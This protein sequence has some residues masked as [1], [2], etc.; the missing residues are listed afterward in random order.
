MEKKSI[1]SFIAALRKANG[2]TQ[3][4]LAEK[5]NVSDKTVSRWE[6][7]EGTPDLSL[8]PVI[9]EL[10]GVTS[11]ELLLGQRR[12]SPPPTAQNSGEKQR[13]RLLSA[14][15]ARYRNATCL[16]AGLAL[17]GL[18]AALVGNF[19]F[20]RAYLGFF[21]GAALLLAAGIIQVAAVN[22][23]FLAIDSEDI[24]PEQTA[25]YRRQVIRAAERLSG[26]IA[27]LLG[28]TLSLLL[29]GD[30]YLGLS[31]ASFF[32][33]GLLFGAA[34]LVVWAAALWG[35][36][37]HLVKRGIFPL[38]ARQSAV[39][40]HNFRLKKYCV[41]ALAGVLALTALF[42]GLATGF[43]DT[44]RVA[45]GTVFTDIADFQAYM[46][47]DVP[48]DESCLIG[49]T[50]PESVEEVLKD[51]QYFDQWGNPI[52]VEDALTQVITSPAGNEL[53]RFVER[54]HAVATWH[55]SFIGE[56]FQSATAYTYDQMDA[57]REKIH[58]ANSLFSAV[59]LAECAA[60]LLVYAW[61]RRRL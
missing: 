1:G 30:A 49:D 44:S 56:E 10:F 19:A 17:C 32:R 29:V 52:S 13:R 22:A 61:K 9:A 24:A 48:L 60:G 37:H 33:Y 28:I 2:L 23:A 53:C 46:E 43:G 3:R 20:L 59:Y 50:A 42:H 11:D 40:Q 41:A 5:L 58:T 55:C 12:S 57:A 7:D 16:A 35:I 51:T 39:Y 34:A 54:N 6:R 18:I 8:I 47:Q 45:E 25:P 36:H 15:L 31:A 27:V 14:S 38:D 26:L 4:E 21:A